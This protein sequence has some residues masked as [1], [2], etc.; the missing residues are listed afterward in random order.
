MAYS[1]NDYVGNGV[2]KNF[3]APSYLE[4]A[5][6]K[7]YIN[8][9]E[10]AYTWLNATQ[11]TLES[12]PLVNAKVRVARTTPIS[13]KL[14]DFQN[15]SLLDEV[16]LDTNTD[17]MLYAVQESVD[18]SNNTLK[19]DIN[20]NFDANNK[21]ITNVAEPVNTSDAATMASAQ[22]QVDTA[23]QEHEATLHTAA[24]VGLVL[25]DE[26]D[27]ATYIFL[28]ERFEHL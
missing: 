12:A 1:Y 14:V 8:G 2:S 6:I 27:A 25:A 23:L 15:A 16:S 13:S 7:V 17:F 22:A 10:T 20:S 4:K 3:T 28:A 24:G 11:I 19:Q 5:H 21:R 18:A 9:A 26:Y